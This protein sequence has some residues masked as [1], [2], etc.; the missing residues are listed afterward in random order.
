M[1][2]GSTYFRVNMGIPC[3]IVDFQLQVAEGNHIVRNAKDRLVLT[4]RFTETLNELFNEDSSESE[5]SSE[6]STFGV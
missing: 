1:E 6:N 2:E 4:E 5:D 3:T